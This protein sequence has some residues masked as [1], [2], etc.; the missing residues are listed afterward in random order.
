MATRTSNV[1]APIAQDH[2]AQVVQGSGAARAINASEEA[3]CS[4]RRSVG[5]LLKGTDIKFAE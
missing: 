4:A 3:G 1:A 2:P 5:G